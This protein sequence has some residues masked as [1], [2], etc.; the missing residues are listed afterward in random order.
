MKFIKLNLL[1][2]LL[3]VIGFAQA[4]VSCDTEKCSYTGTVK[5][6]YVNAYGQILVYLDKSYPELLTGA[7]ALGYDAVTSPNA[8]VIRINADDGSLDAK[9]SE[10]AKLFYSTALTAQATGAE[11]TMQARI[12]SGGYMMADRVWLKD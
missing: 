10:V 11:V 9:R 5:T 2:S 6:V 1:L 7:S 12:G 4:D 3:C 8:L